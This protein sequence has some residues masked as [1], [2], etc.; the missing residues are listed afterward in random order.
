MLDGAE[1]VAVGSQEFGEHAGI[2]LIAFAVVLVD[3]A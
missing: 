3:G 2:E 1:E